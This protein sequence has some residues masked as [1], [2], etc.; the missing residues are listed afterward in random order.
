[1]CCIFGLG[2]HKWTWKTW[3]RNIPGMEKAMK[4]L[5]TQTPAMT[6]HHA[7][8]RTFSANTQGFRKAHDFQVLFTQILPS[9]IIATP[10]LHKQDAPTELYL[11]EFTA[12]ASTHV[13][14]RD[15][16][17]RM[18]LCGFLFTHWFQFFHSSKAIKF[19]HHLMLHHARSQALWGPTNNFWTYALE[20]LMKFAKDMK[21]GGRQVAKDVA[22]TCYKS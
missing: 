1:M 12:L 10:F 14:T 4:K 5:C 15:Q 11:L 20:R 13:T 7:A 2:V 17:C 8:S 6:L 16:L 18:Q 9:L 19:C 22:K 3:K 21:T